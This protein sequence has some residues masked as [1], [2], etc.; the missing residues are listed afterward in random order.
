MKKLIIII[1]TVILFQS[2]KKNF[3]ETNINPNSPAN[4]TTDLVING[5]QVTSILFYEGE[6]ARLGNMWSGAFSGEDRQYAGLSKY[7]TSSTDYDGAWSN[8]YRGVFGQCLLVEAEAAKINNRIQAGIS[9]IM[10][11]QI[12]GTLASLWGDV[13]FKEA[14]QGAKFPKP[15]YD[16][17]ADVYMSVQTLLTTAIADLTSNVGIS[18]GSKDIFYGGNRNAWIRAA[19]SL[20][21]RFY[22]HVK[23]YPNAY[24]NALLGIS[25][26]DGDM[27]APHG[28]TRSQDFNIYY[29]F[30]VYDRAG[31]MAGNGLAAQMLDAST[32][33]Y[34]GNAKTDETARF[35]YY[36]LKDFG[37]FNSGYEVN[38]LCDDIGFAPDGAGFF[39]AET[40]HPLITYAETQLIAAEAAIRLPAPDFS[41]ALTAL[42]NHRAALT[43]Y[44]PAAYQLY[45]FK[46]DPLTNADFNAGGIENAG[47][48]TPAAALLKEII[49]E[50]YSTLIGQIEHFNDIR[51]TKN[52]IGVTPTIGTQL[53]QRFLYSQQEI[54]TN[55]NTPKLATSDLFKPTT[56][57]N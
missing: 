36:F 5:A 14:G 42:N 32:S 10:R 52:A 35:N 6:M 13:P 57:N 9:K 51:R 54:N 18:P 28:F 7:L 15:K 23:D 19:H 8:A 1:V 16:A 20:K 25:T 38:F 29:S 45:G 49:E 21:A 12:A 33:K 27:I 26:V 43:N 47:S 4:A 56:V 11:A 34:R 41:N 37:V 2:C 53:P 48:I 3:E 24:A 17:Q 22:L 50:R 30:T 46:Y 40:K 31:Y 44:I 55:P 39:G